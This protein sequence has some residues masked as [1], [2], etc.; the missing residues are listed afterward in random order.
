MAWDIVKWESYS[1]R[2]LL[3]RKYDSE[4]VLRKHNSDIYAIFTGVHTERCLKYT[5]R[6]MNKGI[7]LKERTSLL[8]NFILSILDIIRS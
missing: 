2:D 7:K 1:P 6:K 8:I 4:G 3:S 5:H